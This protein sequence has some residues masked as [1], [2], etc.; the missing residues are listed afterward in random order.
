MKKTLFAI[1]VAIGLIA[2]ITAYS[3]SGEKEETQPF[4]C[5]C[6]IFGRNCS[7]AGWGSTCA[8]SHVVTCW[9]YDAEC[10]STHNLERD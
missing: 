2:S 6:R 4:K 5:Q 10:S 9:T 7:S 8:P 3:N 1:S